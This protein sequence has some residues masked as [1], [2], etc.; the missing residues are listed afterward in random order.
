MNPLFLIRKKFNFYLIFYCFFYSTILTSQEN[1]GYNNFDKVC[2]KS[3]AYYLYFYT[4]VTYEPSWS[5][6]KKYTSVDNKIVIN[7]SK[8]VDE[9]AF[10]KLDEYEANHIKKIE[11]KTLKANGTI[12]KL[13]SSIVFK[14]DAKTKK[15]D[16]IN[17]PIPGV[18]PGDTI[19]TAYTYYEILKKNELKNYVSLHKNIPSINSQ[20]TIKTNP[21]MIVKYKNYNNFPEPTVVSNDSLLYVQFSEDKLKPFLET[22][23]SCLP[24]DL[25]YTYYTLNK[26]NDKLRTWGN[27]YNEEFNFLTLPMAIDLDR[28]S[29]FKRWKKRTLD[30]AKDSSKYYKF[31]FLYNTVLNDFEIAEAQPYEFIKSSGHFLKEKRFDNIS[32][33]RFYRQLLEDLEIEYWAVFAKS[34]R[35][36]EIDFDYIRNGEFDHIFFAYK[37]ESDNLQ[38]IYPH[39]NIFKYQL[40]EIPTSLYNT[41]AV[42]VKP[43]IR[44]S[45]KKKK[46][47]FI[48][49]ELQIA[50]EDS[51][52]IAK[53]ILP[54]MNST[55]N[56]VDQ[57]VYGDV[58]LEAKKVTFKSRLL[59]SGGLSTEL[60]NYFSEMNQNKELGEYYDALYKIEGDN[61]LKIDSIFKT[62]LNNEKPFSYVI[63]SSGKLNNTISFIN[64]GMM[65]L[66]VEKLLSHNI[67]ETTLNEDNLHYYLDYKYSD[68]FQLY[69]NFPNEIEIIGTENS[70]ITFKNDYGEFSF[71]I[72]QMKKNQVKIKSSYKITKDFISKEDLVH[73]EKLNDELKR[74]KS[75]RFIIKTIAN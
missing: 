71:E 39:N 50:K 46:E 42:M 25:P 6:Y 64:D 12:I 52:T 44:A 69:L 16:A 63:N 60:R 21:E 40:N 29:Y 51:V 8:G 22:K 72:K 57:I 54:G 59:V 34:K 2:K 5:S 75:K 4:D 48:T 68:D 24:C 17:Y 55:Y 1:L 11:I 36:G 66:S 10:L 35:K 67:V 41:Q 31:E 49:R 70:T 30:E 9:F 19:Y 14:K 74:A 53:V 61:T 37:D 32:I 18:E 38:F 15:I 7:N 13:D 62:Y 20:Y 27:V 28:S 73:I 43:V 47:K 56:R 58:K 26:K 33:R 65:S 3:D 45:E 23:Y